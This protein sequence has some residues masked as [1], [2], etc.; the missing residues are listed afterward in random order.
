M[1][2]RSRLAAIHRG[3]PS[4]ADLGRSYSRGQCGCERCLIWAKR[5]LVVGSP[6]GKRSIRTH[7]G[8]GYHGA[9]GYRGT[10]RYYRTYRQYWDNWRNWLNWVYGTYWRY[11]TYR[12]NWP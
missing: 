7:W 1:G 11:G 10:Y 4:N 5:Q 6:V 3:S 8:D 9:Y 2:P 12:P